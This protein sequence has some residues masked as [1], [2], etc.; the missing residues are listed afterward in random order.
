VQEI[1]AEVKPDYEQSIYRYRHRDGSYG[2]RWDRRASAGKQR[3]VAGVGLGGKGAV[4][5]RPTRR[6][7]ESDQLDRITRA[8]SGP[9]SC[10]EPL[11]G[12]T[13]LG[14]PST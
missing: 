11:A 6:S 8:V 12:G 1:A 3:T 4:A 14:D 13:P 7:T 10:E 2:W 9:V 5:G